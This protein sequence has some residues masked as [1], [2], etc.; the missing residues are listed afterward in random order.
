MANSA[1]MREWWDTRRNH[2]TLYISQ[3]VLDEVAQGNTEMATR[4]LE[5]LR[6]FP[7]SK[8]VKLSKI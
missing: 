2:F 4:R 6:D 5:I 1:A 3:V 7:C 8:L